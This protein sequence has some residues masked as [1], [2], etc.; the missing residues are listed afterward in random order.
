[1]AEEATTKSAASAASSV[2]SSILTSLAST[3]SHALEA[4]SSA[5]AGGGGEHS[6]GATSEGAAGE[7]TSEHAGAEAT[8]GGAEAGG[9]TE[10]ADVL[11][12]SN[13]AI[14]AVGCIGLLL[15]LC[16]IV[17][18]THKASRNKRKKHRPTD[19]ED[20]EQLS[21]DVL[22]SAG[23]IP[24]Y[25]KDGTLLATRRFE[26]DDELKTLDQWQTREVQD[27]A[28]REGKTAKEAWLKALRKTR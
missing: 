5:A 21:K 24:Q 19:F 10:G 9:A 6:G 15:L 14:I 3:A 26:F 12:N 11:K 28:D 17:S 18:F 27:A 7:A 1:M 22:E 13:A 2:L 25:N 20:V 16:L 23:G 4:S 8:G